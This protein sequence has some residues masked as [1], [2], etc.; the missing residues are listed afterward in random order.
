MSTSSIQRPIISVV[1]KRGKKQIKNGGRQ[2]TKGYRNLISGL[3]L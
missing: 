1:L 3:E 2:K